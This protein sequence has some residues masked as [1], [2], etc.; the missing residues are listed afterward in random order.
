MQNRS[1]SSYLYTTMSVLNNLEVLQHKC[2]DELK[3]TIIRDMAWDLSSF[4]LRS[5]HLQE[6][7]GADTTE[8]RMTAYV[9][10]PE[11]FHEIVRQEALRIASTLERGS[12]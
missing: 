3:E 1:L 12:L 7:K 6:Q 2:L 8:F 11:K 10:P 5:G 4:V 9:I